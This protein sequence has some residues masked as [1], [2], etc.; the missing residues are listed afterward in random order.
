[1][2]TVEGKAKALAKRFWPTVEADLIDITNQD[3]V[4]R[5]VEPLEM[6]QTVTKDEVYSVLKRVKLDKCLKID[7]IPNR[8]L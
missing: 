5:A 4:T 6:R 3:F 8:F 1:M 2:S 7:G